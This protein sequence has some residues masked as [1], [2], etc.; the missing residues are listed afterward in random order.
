[1][2][3]KV[4]VISNMPHTIGILLPNL[5]LRAEWRKKGAK[6]LIDK[7]VLEQ[8]MFDPGTEY[9]FQNGMLYIEDMK[10]K[11]DL[12]IE[13]PG[14]EEPEN[15]IILTDAQ[16]SELM[17][18]KKQAWELKEKLSKMSY[19]GKKDFCDYVIEHELMD[20]KKSLIIK[21]ICGIDT[22]NAIRMK[23][24]NEAD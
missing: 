21:E 2:S 5:N 18:S 1:M 10:T 12:G 13:P 19:E 17:S 4:T 9:M 3:E 6:V 11:I 15:V 8:A 23:Q 20:S 14:A 7:E 24:A 22:V 16:K